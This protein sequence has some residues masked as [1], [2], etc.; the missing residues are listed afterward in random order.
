[1]VVL[2]GTEAGGGARRWGNGV[3]EGKG[4]ASTRLESGLMEEK[5]KSEWY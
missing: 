3:G 1:M 4:G 5:E 2:S